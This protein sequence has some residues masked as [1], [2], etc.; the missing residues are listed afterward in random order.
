MQAVI[1][2]MEAFHS[3][4]EV[5]PVTTTGNNSVVVFEAFGKFSHRCL[6]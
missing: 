2:L 3:V 1:V 5:E 4:K 6:C